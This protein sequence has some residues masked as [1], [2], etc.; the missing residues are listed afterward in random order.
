MQYITRLCGASSGIWFWL[1]GAIYESN[2][3]HSITREQEKRDSSHRSNVKPNEGKTQLQTARDEIEEK[4]NIEIKPINLN[5]SNECCW[6]WA[7]VVLCFAFFG[8]YFI[9]FR[10]FY[11]R[12]VVNVCE[13]TMHTHLFYAFYAYGRVEILKF[14]HMRPIECKRHDRSMISNWNF[15]GNRRANNHKCSFWFDS[16]HRLCAWCYQ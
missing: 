13:R 4:Q 8:C 7:S 1:C 6:F 15:H 3:E 12:F 14:I 5:F 16:R 11:V 10:R 2:R 9:C